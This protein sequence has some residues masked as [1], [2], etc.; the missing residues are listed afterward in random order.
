LLK[1]KKQE[2]YALKL[3]SKVLLGGLVLIVEIFLLAVILLYAILAENYPIA[4]AQRELLLMQ[5][6]VFA[7]VLGIVAFVF[8][9]LGYNNKLGKWT[10]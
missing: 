9:V 7:I 4:E 3:L 10:R 2:E 6:I 8:Q 1:I 5:T